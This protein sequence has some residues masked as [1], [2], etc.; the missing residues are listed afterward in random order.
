VLF[1]EILRVA[2]D[3]LLANKLRS[4]LT[5]LGVIIGIASVITMMAL[6]EGA[7]RR[8]A[9][10][11]QALGTNVFTIRPGQGFH[12]GV[13]TGQ[14]QLTI[15]DAEVLREEAK[16]VVGVAPELDGRYQVELRERNASLSVVGSWPSYFEVNNF[17][18]AA[19]RLFDEAEDRARR[20]VAVVGA[21]V[22]AQLGLSSSAPLLG[23]TVRI[24][25]IPFE[26]IGVL[27]EKGSS[28]WSSPDENVFIPLLTARVRVV[29]SDRI[30][31]IGLKA[32]SEAQMEEA[33]E[34]VEEILRRQRRVRAGQPSDFQIRDQASLWAT[35]QETA[36]TIGFLLAGIAVISLVVGGIG[37]MNIMLV[38][39]T[40]RTREIG[41]RKALG[42]RR[43]DILGQFLVESLVLCLMGGALGLAVGWGAALL[44]ERLAGWNVAVASDAVLMAFGFSAAVGLFF[45]LWPARK[46]A[47]LSPI[48]AL[49][50]E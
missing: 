39:V 20:R 6:G 44:L 34:E 19:G 46:A 45:G 30:R 47:S 24:R 1:L 4:L 41:L 33:M 25:G 11:L 13:S 50:H 5:M 23:E 49:R 18:L 48:E 32:R 12:G 36:K 22:G 40:E 17:E 10:R 21:M 35:V 15:G 37:I 28:G 8:V 26:V 29:G 14:T 16:L 42:A 43:R 27:A 7:Q 9:E 31:S 3:A 38:S 2:F